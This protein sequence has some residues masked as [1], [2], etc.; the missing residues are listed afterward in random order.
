MRDLLITKPFVADVFTEIFETSSTIL[1][2]MP[3]I[4]TASGLLPFSPSNE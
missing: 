1:S 2:S 3:D 4:K